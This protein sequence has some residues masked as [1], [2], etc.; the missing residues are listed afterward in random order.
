[1]G[2]F[3]KLNASLLNAFSTANTSPKLGAMWW[4]RQAR[5]QLLLP[6]RI[7]SRGEN[8]QARSTCPR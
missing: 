3:N 2:L 1:M 8:K 4:M 7:H 5:L 6:S